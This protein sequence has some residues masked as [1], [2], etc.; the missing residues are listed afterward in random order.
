MVRWLS[1]PANFL[2]ASGPAP[3]KAHKMNGIEHTQAKPSSWFRLGR[4]RLKNIEGLCLLGSVHSV[5]CPPNV[6]PVTGRSINCSPNVFPVTREPMNCPPN[7]FPVTGESINCPPNVFPVTGES[8]NCSPNV[9]PV[10]GESINCSPNV[11]G[12]I[13]RQVN[14][15]P[16]L[17]GEPKIP[18]SSKAPFTSR[19]WVLWIGNKT[20]L[21]CRSL[22]STGDFDL[23]ILI[24]ACSEV[25]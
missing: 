8:I 15:R 20:C 17:P 12:P 6:F 24:A 2:G 3:V 16:E 4:V 23:V 21:S 10:T 13:A 7:V 25:I 11:F 22:A 1:P 14:R 5:N 9:F 19:R 18:P